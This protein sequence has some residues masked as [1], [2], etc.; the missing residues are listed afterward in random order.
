MDIGIGLPSTIP[1]ADGRQVLDWARRSEEKGFKSVGTLD[2]LVYP[3]YEPLV[4]LA[5]VAAVTERIELTTA[6]LIVPWRANPALLAKQAATIDHLSGGRLVLGVAVGGRDDDYAVSGGDFHT[7]G[8]R[9]DEMLGGG[10]GI[11]A[12][13]PGAGGGAG[14]AP[15]PRGRPTPVPR[16]PPPPR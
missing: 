5:A 12:G 9:F 7:R 2:R 13:E 14:G 15:P 11:W 1:G 10:E 6:I 8:R 16:G 3:N 4:T